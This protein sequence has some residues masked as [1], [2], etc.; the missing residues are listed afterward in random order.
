MPNV[1]EVTIQRLSVRF[2]VS[3]PLA[4][5]TSRTVPYR[6]F[7][8][9]QVTG[10]LAAPKRNL[11]RCEQLD[12]FR[13]TDSGLHPSQA[14]S[15]QSWHR[16]GKIHASLPLFLSTSSSYVWAPRLYDPTICSRDVGKPEEW[17][18]EERERETGAVPKYNVL[19]LD[20]SIR[21]LSNSTPPPAPG[22]STFNSWEDV[23]S[24]FS[25][26]TKTPFC[27]ENLS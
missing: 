17:N 8:D 25:P 16:S 20:C 1:K 27:S 18:D 26:T 24:L 14:F 11:A 7:V 12:T 19:P 9:Q 23:I 21:V 6:H 15:V 4:R 2:V 5:S 3:G 22:P 13:P 10:T